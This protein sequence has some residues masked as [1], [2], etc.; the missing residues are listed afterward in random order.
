MIIAVN[1]GFKAGGLAGNDDRVFEYFS[2]LALLHPQHHFIFIVAKDFDEKNINAENCMAVIAGSATTNPLLL[3]YRLNYTIPA[4]L[5]KHKSD[6]FVSSG[7]CSL[8]TKVPQCLLVN[9]LSF[10]HQPGLYTNSWLRFYKKNTAKF[11]AGSKTIVV[12]SQFLKQQVVD[13]YKKDPAAVSVL[14][15]GAGEIYRPATWQEKDAVKETYTEG[16]E[17][18]LYS[19]PIDP[20]QNLFNL[21][22]AFSF[23]KKRQKSN[24]QLII[25]SHSAATDKALIR[26]LGSFKYRHEVK[27]L[28][29]LPATTMATITATAYALVFP[30]IYENFAGSIIAAMQSAVPVIAGNGPV[31][32]QIYGDSVLYANTAD[33]ND[34]ADKMMMLFKDE[35][36]RNET[37]SKGSELSAL[38]DV[39]ETMSALWKTVLKSADASF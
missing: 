24:M 11:I 38:Y 27:L 23:F 37:I 26:S 5:R 36:K 15:F 17:Y 39:A 1:T 16:L 33:F 8:R 4:I 32:K 2:N 7:C 19:G 3:Q 6:V 18:F 35:N 9:D 34:I 28:D 13:N 20:K 14:R 30:S 22:K 21:L 31:I 10:L 29:K 12:G 25:A